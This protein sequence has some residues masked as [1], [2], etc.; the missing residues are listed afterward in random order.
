MTVYLRRRGSRFTPT[1]QTAPDTE[2]DA[3]DAAAR[4]SSVPRKP[5]GSRPIGWADIAAAYWPAVVQAR[6]A[7][8]NGERRDG[9]E[10]GMQVGSGLPPN[11]TGITPFDVC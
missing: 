7:S 4:A 11:F 2:S 1:R 5:T 8:A 3:R 6:Q 9:R 10:G